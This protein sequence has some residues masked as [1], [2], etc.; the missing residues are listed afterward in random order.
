[1]TVVSKSEASAGGVSFY[2]QA[3]GRSFFLA[4]IIFVDLHLKINRAINCSSDAPIGMFSR[5]YITGRN[6]TLFY[7]C[8]MATIG[9]SN[10]E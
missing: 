3:L 2:V 1:M 4:I 8:F 5:V 6:A 7:E 9:G 10:A